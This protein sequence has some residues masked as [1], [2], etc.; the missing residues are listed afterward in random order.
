[1]VLGV[2]AASVAVQIALLPIG[3]IVFSRVALAAPLL[4]VFAVPAMSVVQLAG[5]LAVVSWR[6][7]PWVAD[8]AATVTGW[9]CAVLVDSPTWIAGAEWL[10]WRVPPPD[11]A[12]VIG[13]YATAV[14]AVFTKRPRWTLGLVSVAL[15]FV[16]LLPVWPAAVSER[17]PRG[18]LRVTWIDVGQG[19]ATL[20]EFP[21]GRSLLIDGGNRSA[22]FDAGERVVAPALWA[23]GLRR[24]DWVAMS[25]ADADHAG[26]LAAVSRAF[27]P[28]EVW[29]G[30]P[31]PAEPE[32]VALRSAA[33]HAGATWRELRRG[34]RLQIDDVLV[35]VLHPDI[36]DWERRRVRNTDSLVVRVR[37]GA[38]DVLLTGDID[39]QV[40]DRLASEL[41]AFE[42]RGG[43]RLLK[44]AHHGSRTST[45]PALLGAFRP[46][47]AVISVGRSNPFGHPAREVLDRLATSGVEILRT[48]R[49]GAVTLE[50]DGRSAELGTWTGRRFRAIVPAAPP[51]S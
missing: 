38:V 12:W 16:A 26:G 31:V 37:F 28:G 22:N 11:L 8:A 27:T 43:I 47:A 19:D 18:W 35:E 5:L 29:E 20:V 23:L 30:L 21:R 4:N 41:G 10:A 6:V 50:T 2:L 42:D 51:R 40:E 45:S 46:W 24:L 7:L 36:P 33:A 32:R 25:H 34:D 49:D 39:R 15:L 13:F 48:D 3:A 9:A 1:M 44:V 17:P 14:L